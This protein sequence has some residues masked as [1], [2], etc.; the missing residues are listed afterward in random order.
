[1]ADSPTHARLSSKQPAA[2][3]KRTG[4]TGK[5]SFQ[6]EYSLEPARAFLA[7]HAPTVADDIRRRGKHIAVT[8]SSRRLLVADV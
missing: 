6:P 2:L 5:S 3:L 7:H 8:R 4:L 1:V